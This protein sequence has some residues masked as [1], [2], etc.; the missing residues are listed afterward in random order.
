MPI[1]IDKKREYNRNWMNQWRKD[2]DS[3]TKHALWNAASK[4]YQKKMKDN[5]P[6]ILKQ[7]NV[8]QN[9]RHRDK[10][11]EWNLIHK[12]GI[13]LKDYK[14]ILEQQG[15]KCAICGETGPGGGRVNFYVDHDH[16]TNKVRGLL[17]HSCNVGLGHFR[18]SRDILSAAMQYLGDK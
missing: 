7:R 4:R 6:E 13:T 16:V 9:V 10:R 17:C 2:T 15:N 5:F 3:D 1:D 14:S 8:V 11:I 12:Y 18:D